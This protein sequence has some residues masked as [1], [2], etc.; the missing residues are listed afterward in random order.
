MKC[1]DLETYAL[2]QMDGTLSGS[3]AAEW[4][5]HLA[6][7]AACADR[8]RGLLEVNHLLDAWEPIQ[9]SASFNSRLQQRILQQ[10]AL[11]WWERVKMQMALLPVW[12]PAA[13]MAMLAV[14]VSALAVVQYG[15]PGSAA[16]SQR[17][18]G[19]DRVPAQVSTSG[20]E[21]ALYQDLAVLEDWEM[22]SNFEV[23]QELE[24]TR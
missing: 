18:T 12:R 24:A 2:A 1:S 20:D 15:L 14:M 16:I 21:L 19:D 5:R 3:E 10:P 22:L 8:S 7:C 23:L 9:P 6:S 17:Y 13:A 4:E 11:S